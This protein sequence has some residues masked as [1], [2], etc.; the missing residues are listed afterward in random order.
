MLDSLLEHQRSKPGVTF[1]SEEPLTFGDLAFVLSEL[2]IEEAK[3]ERLVYDSP[4]HDKKPD[5]S[6]LI[7]GPAGGGGIIC[8]GCQGTNFDPHP[9]GNGVECVTCG[10]HIGGGGGAPGATEGLTIGGNGEEGK[11]FAGGAG[12]VSGWPRV[13]HDVPVVAVEGLEGDVCVTSLEHSEAILMSYHSVE[14]SEVEEAKNTLRGLW[15]REAYPMIKLVPKGK[16]NAR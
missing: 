15:M 6:I 7:I 16:P 3:S 11:R 2:A 12:D 1:T 4:D 8:P 9:S 5:F 10:F 13:V 14:R